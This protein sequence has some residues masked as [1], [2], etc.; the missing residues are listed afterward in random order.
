MNTSMDKK[1]ILKEIE[2]LIRSIKVHYENIETEYRI[3]TIELELITSKIRKL[4]EKSIIYNHLHYLEEDQ[5]QSARRH[6]IDQLI[7][8][9]VDDEQAEKNVMETK[10]AII[11]EQ[12]VEPPVTNITPAE[13]VVEPLSAN[14]ALVHND[15]AEIA[16]TPITDKQIEADEPKAVT[17]AP[18]V[19]NT[20][21]KVVIG[22]KLGIN[23]RFRFI[24]NLFGGNGATMEEAIKQLESCSDAHSLHVCVQGFK[25][26]F[27]WQDDDEHVIDFL[28]MLK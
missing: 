17:S 27:N 26:Q 4:H 5:L 1:A 18:A 22:S 8:K 6:K 15:E 12:V 13:T 20:F 23:D 21:K 14:S 7:L 10:S 28:E 2:V 11:K 24:K 9:D 25:Q 3:P 16:P 19:E